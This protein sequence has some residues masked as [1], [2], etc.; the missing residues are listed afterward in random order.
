MIEKRLTKNGDVHYRV[1]IRKKGYEPVSE[2]FKKKSDAEKWR[3]KTLADMDNR[4]YVP[5]SKQPVAELFEKYRD[6]VTPRKPGARWEKVRLEKFLRTASFMR[7]T[8]G[9]MS[10]RDMQA[11][12]DARLL[13]V[14]DASVRRELNLISAVFTHARTNGTWRCLRTRCPGASG[15][16]IRRTV[17]GASVRRKWMACGSTLIRSW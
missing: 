6:E 5:D 15:L 2:T 1:L 17:N 9:Q 12:R 7:Q 14:S 10:Y 4:V 13:Q 3:R 16:R 8:V 11:W